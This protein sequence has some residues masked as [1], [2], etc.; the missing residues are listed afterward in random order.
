MAKGSRLVGAITGI[1][2]SLA[3]SNITKADDRPFPQFSA[4]CDKQAPS[5]QAGKD[6][7]PAYFQIVFP[8]GCDVTEV[9]VSC[10]YSIPPPT[11]KRTESGFVVYDSLMLTGDTTDSTGH[12]CQVDPI[13]AHPRPKGSLVP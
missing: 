7:G 2:F 12:S 9:T 6:W 3:A 5:P 11:V 1:D 4:S 10:N 8:K 13:Y